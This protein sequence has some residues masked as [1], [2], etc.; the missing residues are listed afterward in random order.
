MTDALS[1]Q[2]ASSALRHTQIGRWLID[3]ESAIEAWDWPVAAELLRSVLRIEPAH[4]VGGAAA[5]DVG[6]WAGS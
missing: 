3:A 6:L 5:I 2:A 4:A 1:R